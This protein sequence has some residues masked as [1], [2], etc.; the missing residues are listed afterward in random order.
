MAKLPNTY[1]IPFKEDAIDSVVVKQPGALLSYFKALIKSLR[2]MYSEI[3]NVFNTH[4]HAADYAPIA[5]GVTNG[6]SHDH[7]GGDGAQIAHGN[8]S[9][10]SPASSTHVTNGDS[11][12]HSGGDGGQIAYS[13]L[14]GLPLLQTVVNIGDWNMDSTASVNVA[15]GLT[16]SKIRAIKIL[17][18]RDDGAILSTIGSSYTSTLDYFDVNSTNVVINRVAGGAYDNTNYNATSFNRGW[19]VIDHTA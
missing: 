3:A 11:H 1:T 4:D 13:S 9:G 8:L 15:H 16:L 18:Q 10:I 12:D 7:N 6:D 19:I 17:V 14:S 2:D 5:K